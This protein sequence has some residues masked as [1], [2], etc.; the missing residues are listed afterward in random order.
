MPANEEAMKS[1]S[2][3]LQSQIKDVD[4]T[5]IPLLRVFVGNVREIRMGLASEVRTIVQEAVNLREA[6]RVTP[7]INELVKAIGALDKALTPEV[8]AKLQKVLK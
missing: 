8:I 5:L 4:E 3:M 6:T 2:E 7:E 1:F